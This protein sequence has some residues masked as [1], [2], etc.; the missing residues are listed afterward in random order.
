M[1]T[2]PRTCNQTFYHRLTMSCLLHHFIRI[3]SCLCN[4]RMQGTLLKIS[5]KSYLVRLHGN[6][7]QWFLVQGQGFNASCGGD[8]CRVGSCPILPDQFRL[9]EFE[10]PFHWAPLP[11]ISSRANRQTTLALWL[12]LILISAANDSRAPPRQECVPACK[13][14]NA[15]AHLSA[16]C[17]ASYVFNMQRPLGSWTIYMFAKDPHVD[18][19][20]MNTCMTKDGQIARWLIV[21]W[22]TLGC[23]ARPE[24]YH[25]GAASL[26]CQYAWS[27]S[28]MH[29]I[30]NPH[31][32]HRNLPH[33]E[34]CEQLI[35]G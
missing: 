3:Y 4:V 12:V 6:G 14:D 9:R 10:F 15:S 19:P 7:W 2:C 27:T 21:G 24:K 35:T 28:L 32:W 23:A 13:G 33:S 26:F 1:F 8:P 20:E 22:S 29:A 17:C 25:L 31:L 34:P 5:S 16:P 18:D 30:W 11:P